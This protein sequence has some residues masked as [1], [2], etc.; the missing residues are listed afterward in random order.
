MLALRAAQKRDHNALLELLCFR[1]SAATLESSCIT[2]EDQSE[3]AAEATEAVVCRESE[4]LLARLTQLRCGILAER[5]FAERHIAARGRALEERAALG[6]RNREL[7]ETAECE[8]REELK[9]HE[10]R[11]QR[12]ADLEIAVKELSVRARH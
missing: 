10:A 12:I 8:D 11:E 6:K 4:A 3:E 2:L 7:L 9:K 1:R 5:A